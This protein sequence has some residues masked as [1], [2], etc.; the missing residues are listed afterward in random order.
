MKIFLCFL[1][2][3]ASPDP[4]PPELGD[5][6]GCA[7]GGYGGSTG[8]GGPRPGGDQTGGDQQGPQD[9]GGPTT[10]PVDG[11]FIPLGGQMDGG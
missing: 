9:D 4:R 7:G 6:S 10:L 5:C 3:C 8:G 2:A 1:I 11:S